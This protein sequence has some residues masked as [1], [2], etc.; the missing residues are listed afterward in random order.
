MYHF[1]AAD[2]FATG[3]GR[4]VS[5][6]ITRA[7]P[8]TDDYDNN[9]KAGFVDGKWVMRPL[10]PDVTAEAIA[11]REFVELF[12][13]YLA[14]G[15]EHLTKENFIDKWGSFLP[16]SVVNFFEKFSEDSGNFHYYSQFHIN[17]N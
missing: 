14:I 12:G 10:K 7:Y 1:L 4:T 6:L 8:K 9:V 16:T 15:V 2:Y 17:F 11:E 3:E 5:L 13:D